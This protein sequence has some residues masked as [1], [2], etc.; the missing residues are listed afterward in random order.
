MSDAAVQQ[1]LPPLS[2]VRLAV[3]SISLALA[4]F[5][6]VLDVSIANVSI[7][8]LAGDLGVSANQGT[9]VI[10][11]FAVCNAVTVPISGWLSRRFGQVR[12]FVICTL[13]FTF[14]SWLCGFARSFPMLLAFRG[15]QG[16]VAGPMIPLS[17]SLLLACYPRDRRGTANGI[18]G[19]TAV[20]GPVAGPILGG[21]IT[22]NI[23]W[24]WIFYIN[25]PIGL[26]V[27]PLCWALLKDRET[28]TRRDPLDVT[29][30][31]LLIIGVGSL[32]IML[33][34]GNDKAWFQSGYIIA[35]AIIA[36]IFLCVFVVW[37][38][39]AERP[40]VDLTLFRDRNFTI[41]TTVLCLGYMAFFSAIVILP[42][43]L[44]TG[45]G[46][47]PS[48]AGLATASLGMMG[49]VAS[50]IA[51]RLSD[52]MDA[53]ILVTIG[54]TVFAGISFF[55]SNS[56]TQMSFAEIFLP[57]LPWGI[58]TAL[59]FIPLLSIAFSR[60]PQDEVA[61]ASGV[62]NF[63]RQLSLGFGTSLATTLWDNRTS[64]HDH[65]LNS[66][67]TSFEPATQQ[68][69]EQARSL[70]LTDDQVHRQLADIISNQALMMATND[71][72]YLSGWV[73]LAL[74]LLIWF[75]RPAHRH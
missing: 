57:R 60:L 58:G 14:A 70:G 47:T 34:Q 17:Q 39:T 75:A 71:L 5:M 11:V 23:S 51:G 29:G 25:V 62:L 49:V 16:A 72:F 64:F 6:N 31:V 8:T 9:W 69:L 73:F 26:I 52:R 55:T 15:F 22:D 33:D 48:W 66:H 45:L 67:V 41:A 43:W 65:R 20:V 50:P 40:V 12:L 35:L 42:L 46:Y 4:V 54:F 3:A 21:W 19:M 56:S 68:W 63:L 18:F 28:P 13:L 1:S 44:Q 37:E 32:Q 30:L 2:G 36:T 53:R 24:P 10:T 27:A 59:F 74:M 61:S 7:P 38:L